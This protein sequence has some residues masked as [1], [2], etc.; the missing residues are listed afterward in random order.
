VRVTGAGIAHV[1]GVYVPMEDFAGGEAFQQ[2]VNKNGVSNI[3]IRRRSEDSRHSWVITKSPLADGDHLYKRDCGSERGIEEQITPPLFGWMPCTQVTTSPRASPTSPRIVQG[4]PKLKYH[5]GP[6][7]EINWDC[8]PPA[9]GKLDRLSARGMRPG[10]QGVSS[11]LVVSVIGANSIPQTRAREFH[12]ACQALGKNEM[13]ESVLVRAEQ[14]PKFRL[15]TPLY[16]WKPPDDVQF[17]LYADRHIKIGE[18]VLE[19]QYFHE[20]GFVGDVPVTLL[21]SDDQDVSISVCVTVPGQLT[22]SIDVGIRKVHGSKIGIEVAPDSQSNALAITKILAGGLI[23]QWNYDN[24][25]QLVGIRDKIIQ[26]DGERGSCMAMLA[27][28]ARDEPR[29]IEMRIQKDGT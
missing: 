1:N 24:P 5:F 10:Q 27:K 13:I 12:V 25:D 2:E 7:K 20:E 22:P 28:F 9:P 15:K 18:A 19:Y 17:T 16:S 6:L 29:V 14:D 3:Y 4:M 11:S 23:D 26:I 21:G 8:Q